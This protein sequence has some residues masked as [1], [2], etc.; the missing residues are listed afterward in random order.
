MVLYS[1]SPGREPGGTLWH[2][3]LDRER[4]NVEPVESSVHPFPLECQTSLYARPRKEKWSLSQR[5]PQGPGLAGNAC[6]V[7]ALREGIKRF[8]R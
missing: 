2:T 8:W 7:T 5:V 3:G 1:A 4:Q 6:S